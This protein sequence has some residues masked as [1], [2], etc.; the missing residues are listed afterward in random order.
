MSA[1]RNK[2]KFALVV[3]PQVEQVSKRWSWCSFHKQ[4]QRGGERVSIYFSSISFCRLYIIDRYSWQTLIIQLGILVTLKRWITPVQGTKQLWQWHWMRVRWSSSHTLWSLSWDSLAF[5]QLWRRVKY[6]IHF[7][8][9]HTWDSSRLERER[10]NCKWKKSA[11]MNHFPLAGVVTLIKDFEVC[12]DG[13]ILTPE[14]ARILVSVLHCTLLKCQM[15]C[16]LN[17]MLLHTW[18]NCLRNILR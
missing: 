8:L 11:N 17:M 10:K 7:T 3:C 1:K 2:S 5:L 16:Y 15:T 6:I 18:L 14:Q 12:K 13:D 9:L 4:N